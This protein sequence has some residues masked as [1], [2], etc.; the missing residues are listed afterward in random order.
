MDKPRSTSSDPIGELYAGHHHWL[1]TWLRRR[2][3]CPHQASDF[4]QDTF[5]RVLTAG[6]YDPP[7]EP[8]AFLATIARRILIDNGRRLRLEQAYR[9]ELERSIEHM[10]QAFS[11]EQILQAIELLER[12]DRALSRMKARVRETF[13]LRHLE[14]WSQDD[15]ARHH[16]IS[17]RTVQADLVEAMLACDAAMGMS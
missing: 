3:Q 9:E 12:I 17:V 5:Y 13:I 2:L 7:R 1:V 11:P 14:G 8:R 10:D 4:A 15:I 6:H 16:G